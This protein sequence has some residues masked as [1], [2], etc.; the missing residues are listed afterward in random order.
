MALLLPVRDSNNDL[1][2]T[3]VNYTNQLFY[4]AQNAKPCITDYNTNS[5]SARFI[6]VMAN[7]TSR[8]LHRRRR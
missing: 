1:K 8:S 5:F 6:A 4:T 7:T 3:T 2:L